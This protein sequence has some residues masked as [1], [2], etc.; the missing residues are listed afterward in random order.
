MLK[1]YFCEMLV[2]GLV[3]GREKIW[4][5]IFWATFVY[6]LNQLHRPDDG[7]SIHL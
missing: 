4:G 6:I 1:Q 5:I 3:T 7:G 2:P